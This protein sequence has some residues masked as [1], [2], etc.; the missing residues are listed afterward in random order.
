MRFFEDVNLR[1]G[2]PITVAQLAVSAI[3]VLGLFFLIG[4]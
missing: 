1:Y 4:R 3:Y 2:V